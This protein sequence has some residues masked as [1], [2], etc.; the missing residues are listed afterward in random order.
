MNQLINLKV[1]GSRSLIKKIPDL[2]QPI[3]IIFPWLRY[4]F[5]SCI[6]KNH[7]RSLLRQ[8]FML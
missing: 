6:E 2:I 3:G 1:K 7:E 5:L 4:D 8:F